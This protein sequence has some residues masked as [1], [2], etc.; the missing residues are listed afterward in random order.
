MTSPRILLNL[1]GH[2]IDAR[3][4]RSEED[5][6]QGLMECVSLGPEEGMLFIHDEPIDACFWMK[7][8]PLD[9]SIAF[10]DDAG[11]VVNIEEMT[12][13]SLEGTR[14]QARVRYVLE[15]GRGWFADRGIANGATLSGLPHVAVG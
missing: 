14:A 6:A 15:M 8:T 4:A 13:G 11:T 10:V 9:L 1:E 12:A 7:N 2:R 5:R 3:I